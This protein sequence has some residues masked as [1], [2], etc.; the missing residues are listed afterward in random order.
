MIA[1]SGWNPPWHGVIAYVVGLLLIAGAL[2]AGPHV[3]QLWHR[4]RAPLGEPRITLTYEDGKPVLRRAEDV[5]DAEATAFLA[6]VE[7]HVRGRA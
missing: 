7:R 3:Q 6:T 4:R 5:T 1:A 2:K